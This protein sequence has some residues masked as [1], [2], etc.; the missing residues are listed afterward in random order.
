MSLLDWSCPELPTGRPLGSSTRAL[1]YRGLVPLRSLTLDELTIDDETSFRGVAI[2]HRLKEV[3][4]ASG[5]RF[6]VADAGENA[7]WDRALFL[8]LTFWSPT[9]EAS[10]LVDDHVAPDV[11]AHTALH[12]VVGRALAG[13]SAG[14]SPAALLF[15]EAIASA[16]D[17]YL[18]GRLLGIAPDSDFVT[19][20]VP[21]MAEATEQAGL[22]EPAFA[23]L[24]ENVS[25]APERAFEDLR[26][27]LVDVGTALR[28]CADAAAAHIA[29]EG[30]ARHR[31]APLLHHFQLSNWILYGRAYAREDRDGADAVRAF[32]EALRAS[33]DSL[34][35]IEA[36]W[37]GEAP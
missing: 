7:S 3:V 11:V 16:F 18:V 26:A 19:S 8:N 23:R 34:A 9:E 10:V 5:H 12:H 33:P 36:R 29:L 14:T 2:Y 25:A 20:Q 15:A 13:A 22:D 21:L 37:L 27:L 30:F 32:D 28:G 17:L 35:W 24:L 4:R 31:F 1:E 6:K